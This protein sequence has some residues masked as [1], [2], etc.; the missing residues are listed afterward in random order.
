MNQINKHAARS[1]YS[2]TRRHALTH[3]RTRLVDH[4]HDS[5]VQNV[6]D[7]KLFKPYIII[8]H[9]IRYFLVLMRYSTL[10]SGGKRSRYKSKQQTEWSAYN[11]VAAW[12]MCG[13]WESRRL[14][15]LWA[16]NEISL[17]QVAH[18]NKARGC[19][20]RNNRITRSFGRHAVREYEKRN[21]TQQ[22]WI[23]ERERNWHTSICVHITANL[24]GDWTRIL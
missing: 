8:P 15:W 17:H 12:N 19:S 20:I 16:N 23:A 18:M 11:C 2:L 13:C 4:S 10:W 22:Y 24:F 21:S 9:Q 1:R 7:L 6:N 5:T 3:T 14:N